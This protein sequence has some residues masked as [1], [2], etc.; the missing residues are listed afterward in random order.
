MEKIKSHLP[1]LTSNSFLSNNAI[2]LYLAFIKLLIHLI[3]NAIGGYGYFRDE[4]YY[5]ACSDHMAWGYV[6]QPPFSI[7]VLWLNRLLLGD[8]IFVLRFLPAVAGAIVVLIAGLI[9]KELGGNKFAQALAACSVIIAPQLLGMNSYFSMNS[10][11]ILF[12]TIA[13]YL[14]IM[15]IKWDK[16]DY[17]IILGIVLGLGLLNKISVLWLG[18]GLVVGLLLTPNRTL[19]LTRKV[20]F[21]A[22][23]VLLIFLPHLIW[24]IVYNFPTLEFIRN[25]T[26]QK[27][28]AVSPL[29]MFVQQIM[30]MHPFTFPVWLAGLIYLLVSKTVKRFRIL[31]IIY[32][33]VFLIL[34][35]NK[36]SKAEYLTPLFPMLFAAGS[37]IIEKLIQRLNWELVKV[38]R[39]C[40]LNSWR[41]CY[42]TSCNCYIT[43]REIYRLYP[44]NWNG[45]LYVGEKGAKQASPTLC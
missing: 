8:S 24:Q 4:L 33:T 18:A 11:D 3:T 2:L 28:V 29:D 19:F 39:N 31:S 38:C 7:A 30:S 40:T 20:W 16:E 34:V 37:L 43:S 44:I 1:P 14:L 26:S 35:I 15:I 45:T 36:N 21:A 17:W 13:L 6:D 27:Y 10:F 5:I 25:A 9:T 41:H 23:I 42:C 22:G 32:L 12:W